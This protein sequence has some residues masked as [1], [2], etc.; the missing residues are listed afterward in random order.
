MSN[1]SGLTANEALENRSDGMLEMIYQ[2]MEEANRIHTH[3]LVASVHS[4]FAVF[5]KY[6]NLSVLDQQIETLIQM[7]ANNKHRL[8][9][10][11]KQ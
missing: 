1:E 4:D 5:E 6:N 8:Q 3:M 7:R 11:C 2:L 10:V 9:M